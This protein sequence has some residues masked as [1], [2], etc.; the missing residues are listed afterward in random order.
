MYDS[1]RAPLT[2]DHKIVSGGVCFISQPQSCTKW[3]QPGNPVELG[4]PNDSRPA[5]AW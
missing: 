2:I 5:K 4:A 3:A 1:G